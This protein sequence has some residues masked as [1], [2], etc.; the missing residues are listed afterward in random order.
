MPELLNAVSQAGPFGIAAV[1]LYFYKNGQEQ[2]C[3]REKALLAEIED[4]KKERRD[5]QLIINKFLGDLPLLTRSIDAI[6]SEV[7]ELN[8]GGND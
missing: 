1:V 3:S 7:E 2:W 8:G 4:Q 5:S 6:A